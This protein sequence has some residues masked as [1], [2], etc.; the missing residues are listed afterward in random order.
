MQKM[1]QTLYTYLA[2]F[3]ALC[4]S[5]CKKFLDLD[6]ISDVTSAAYYKTAAQAETAL[7]AAYDGMQSANYYGFHEFNLSDVQSDNAEAGG[8]SPDIFQVDNFTATA[9]NLVLLQ[10]WP[11]VYTAI[12]LDNDVID[13]VTKMEDGVFAGERKKQILGEARFLRALNYFN[14]V[15]EYGNIP[16]QLQQVTK[17]DNA[18][19]NLPQSSAGDVYA[20]IIEDLQFAA[21][22]LPAD[23]A[24]GRATK[25]AA[26]GM[27]AK[28]NLTLKDWAKAASLAQQ[29]ID[30]NKYST[31]IPYDNIFTQKHNSEV[32]FDIQYTGGTEGSVL[33]D[34]LLPYPLATFEFKKFGTP[35]PGMIAAYEAGDTR[36]ASS[37]IMQTTIDGPNFPHVYKY[38]NA[39]AFAAP[40]NFI[41]LRYADVK[42][43]LAEALNEIS[44]GD[45]K[46]LAALNEIRQR[47]SLAP[48]SYATLSTQAAFREAVYKERRVELAF[49]GHRWSD[50][51]RTGRA[52]STMQAIYPNITADK[53]ILPIPQT[54]LDKNKALKQNPGYN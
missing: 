19:I 35:S 47:A 43:M 39:A 41:V 51:V 48:L 38:R 30:L 21:D 5:G 4:F 27:L 23:M 13:N 33:P 1:K 17:L 6:P 29:V 42:L 31:N 3:L 54:E 34:L 53:L 36:K 25:G 16:L 12:G 28:V 14:L 22:N 37:I 49:E 18:V 46:A 7:T 24:N 45:P 50:L 32:I 10:H 20:A 15:R 9:T 2:C 40:T 26:L 11:Q 8:D 52:L 44:H